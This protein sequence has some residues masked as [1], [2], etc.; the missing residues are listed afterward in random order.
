MTTIWGWYNATHF[1]YCWGLLNCWVYHLRSLALRMHEI[2]VHWFYCLCTDIVVFRAHVC[3]HAFNPEL[4]KFEVLIMWILPKPSEVERFHGHHN[5]VD[6]FN[7]LQPAPPRPNTCLEN[8]KDPETKQ[9]TSSTLGNQICIFPM[10][11]G[12][13][14]VK[15]P[16]GLFDIFLWNHLFDFRCPAAESLPRHPTLRPYRRPKD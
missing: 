12:S 7:M 11:F 3:W 16:F 4:S 8:E 5:F 10:F 1:W 9:P 14:L 6:G 2:V 15:Q 13:I